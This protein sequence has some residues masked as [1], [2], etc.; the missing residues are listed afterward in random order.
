M[1]QA[2]II[3]ALVF[4]LYSAFTY[5]Q[6]SAQK[7][8]PKIGLVL[9]GGGARGF[10]H[11]GVLQWF[12]EH[13]IPVDYLAGTSMGGLIGG[14]YAIGKTPEEMK[15]IAYNINWIDLFRPVPAF[16]DLS[17]R[18][19]QDRRAFP[20]AIEMG[21]KNGISLPS[22]LNSGHQIGILFSSLTLPYSNIASFDELPIP[23]RCMATDM[24]AAKPVVLSRGSVALAL[25]A[26]MSIPGVFAPVVIEEK[27]LASDG[28]LL[29][30]LPTDV[31]K[32]IGVDIIIAID[33]GTPLG[34]EQSMGSIGGVLG[35]MIGVVT[36][37]NTRRNRR[38]CRHPYYSKSKTI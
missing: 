36:V 5:A 15:E 6:E 29:N 11:I 33:I 8:R 16:E 14:M 18:R 23:F 4:V 34:G 1:K 2:R 31:M 7:P 3:L 9:S 20:N 13:R 19:K 10:A 12:E 27:I 28:G 17:F 37:E 26:T 22:G 35:Q 32:Q 24:I 38:T 25:Q 21:L 30:N